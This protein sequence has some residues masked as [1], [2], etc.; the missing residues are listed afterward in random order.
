MVRKCW[1][2]G[3]SE[4]WKWNSFLCKSENVKKDRG[5]FDEKDIF[6]NRI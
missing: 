6:M 2:I 5:S 4:Y 1:N 3:I